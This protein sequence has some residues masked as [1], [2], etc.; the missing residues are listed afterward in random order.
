M[1]PSCFAVA[2]VCRTWMLM[3]ARPIAR[4]MV[5]S[6]PIRPGPPVAAPR[7]G[8]VIS[9]CSTP[10][11]KQ[12]L[13]A[14]S[15]ASICLR[16]F[17]ASAA[18]YEPYGKSP[19]DPTAYPRVPRSMGRGEQWLDRLA[20]SGVPEL[21]ATKRRLRIPHWSLLDHQALLRTNHTQHVGPVFELVCDA[22]IG[23][24]RCDEPSA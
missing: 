13:G 4:Q 20:S 5:G 12:P 10:H 2:A 21:T 7:P 14:D 19:H 23:D 8:T 6:G 15:G 24:Q 16:L 22:R 11:S 9:T 1:T 17:D 18:G 3:R